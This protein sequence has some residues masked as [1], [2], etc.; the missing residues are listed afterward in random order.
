[1]KKIIKLFDYIMHT[2]FF[3]FQYDENGKQEDSKK[4]TRAL[5]LMILG[6]S[7]PCIYTYICFVIGFKTYVWLFANYGVACMAIGTFL[8]PYF[9][10]A[11]YKK[12][13]PKIVHKYRLDLTMP[14]KHKRITQ[15]FFFLMFSMLFSGI[16]VVQFE[17]PDYKKGPYYQDWD[18]HTREGRENREKRRAN[19][20]ENKEEFKEGLKE[21]WENVKQRLRKP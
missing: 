2:Y 17:F 5:Y 12:R 8:I 16:L 1:M 7:M 20:L 19:Y 4:K 11:I 10:Y 21:D 13:H 6:Y 15:S 3:Q 9:P 18:N 14:E